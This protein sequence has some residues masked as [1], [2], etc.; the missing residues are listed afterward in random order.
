MSAGLPFLLRS[1]RSHAVLPCALAVVP[2][3]RSVGEASLYQS[4]C[5]SSLPRCFG[6]WAVHTWRPPML[7]RGPPSERG[8][9][10]PGVLLVA[11]GATPCAA[12]PL[13]SIAVT[14]MPIVWMALVLR[15]VVSWVLRRA[16][17]S[18]CLGLR[19]LSGSF[20]VYVALALPMD[21]SSTALMVPWCVL[22][23]V[24]FP[25]RGAWHMGWAPPVTRAEARLASLGQATSSRSARPPST[26]TFS[27]FTSGH[28]TMAACTPRSSRWT[29]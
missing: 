5:A 24:M 7:P 22:A 1:R 17:R 8:A 19:P 3:L 13:R 23:P 4:S 15:L 14:S 27:I 21:A 9:P 20:T 16:V 10:Q 29:R 6:L 26:A 2:P 25:P 28:V 11:A 12:S 18:G